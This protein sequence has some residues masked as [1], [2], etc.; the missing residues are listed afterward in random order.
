[1]GLRRACNQAF[2]EAEIVCVDI[3]P[4]L[5]YPVTFVLGDALEIDL[6]G[7]DFAWRQL[8]TRV[9]RQLTPASHAA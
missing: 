8:M 7:F 6:A 5:H 4:Q 3:R 9:R 2:P 1:M